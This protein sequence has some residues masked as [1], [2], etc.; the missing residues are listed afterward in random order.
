ML[1]GLTV[2]EEDAGQ[3]KLRISWPSGAGSIAAAQARYQVA[4]GRQQPGEDALGWASALETFRPILSYEELGKILTGKPSALHDAIANVLGLGELESGITRLDA[5]IKPLT[6]PLTKSTPTRRTL[7]SELSALNDERARRAAALLNKTHPDLDALRGLAAGT[8]MSTGQAILA[9]IGR[10]SLPTERQVQNAADMLEKAESRLA[11]IGAQRSE[12]DRL[13]D[14]L[15]E[16]A[17]AFH[18]AAGAEISCPVCGSGRLDRAWHDRTEDALRGVEL[19]THA[20]REAEEELRL[21]E[22]G[23]RT[24]LTAPPPSIRQTDVALKAQADARD[25]WTAWAT[26]APA[27]NLVTHLRSRFSRVSAAVEAWQSE[28]ES[29]AEARANVWEPY[30]LRIAAWTESHASAVAKDETATRLKAAAQLMQQIETRLRVERLRPI[31]DQAKAIWAE[32]RH[33]S[34]VELHDIVLKGT[35]TRRTVEISAAV[36][37]AA[38]KAISVMS[39]GELHAL[40]LALFLPRATADQSPF[41]FLVLDDPVQAMDPAKVEGLAAVLAE[42]ARKRQVVV[43]SHDDRLAQ[44]CRRLP[45]RPTVLEVRRERGSQVVVRKASTPTVGHL[46]D[47]WALLKDDRLDEA[48]KRRILPGVLRQAVESALWERY[49]ADRLRRGD[50]IVDVEDAWD[51][52]T[53]TWLRLELVLGVNPPTW[54]R[55]QPSRSRALDVCRMHGP[56]TGDLEEALSDVRATVARS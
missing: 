12:L 50:A 40:A 32:L 35:N 49:A 1:I 17:L 51:R 3:S 27:D 33:E 28:A 16:E 24:L 54:L 45:I 5:R 38:T 43:F 55:R 18:A 9:A 52:A 4:K 14:A 23:A 10:V 15:L 30:A 7:R 34:N 25:A 47:A 31:V 21:A 19:L 8:T 11:L 2:Y 6:A 13:R 39:Q 48:I 42:I 46:E 29:E 20:R 44:A 41:R 22:R 26:P 53:T 36:D 56:L 37:D